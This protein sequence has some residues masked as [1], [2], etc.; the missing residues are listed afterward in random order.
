MRCK[1][2]C[3]ETECHTLVSGRDWDEHFS[4]LSSITTTVNSKIALVEKCYSVT[5]YLFLIHLEILILMT[6]L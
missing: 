3:I 1:Y 4:K 2:D 6:E 5:Y